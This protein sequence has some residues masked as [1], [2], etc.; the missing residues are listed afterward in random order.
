MKIAVVFTAIKV[1]HT[2]TK[3]RLNVAENGKSLVA[4]LEGM[5]SGNKKVEAGIQAVER[6]KQTGKWNLVRRERGLEYSK[7]NL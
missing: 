2:S 7:Y 5:R 3:T 6:K 4:F 1:I